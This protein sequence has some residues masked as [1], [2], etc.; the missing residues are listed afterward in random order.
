MYTR[1]IYAIVNIYMNVYIV[2][3]GVALERHVPETSYLCVG[4]KKP[5]A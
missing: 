4:G 2:A 3:Y 1:A 5:P